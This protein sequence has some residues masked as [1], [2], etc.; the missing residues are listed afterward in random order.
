MHQMTLIL[1]GAVSCLSAALAQ[2]GGIQGTVTSIAPNPVGD[3]PVIATAVAGA[4]ITYRRVPIYGPA[5]AGSMPQLAPGEVL[6]DTSVVADANGKHTVSGLPAGNYVVC[7]AAA[8]QPLLD[9]CRWG[10]S[11]F[12][13]VQIGSI[14]NLNIQLE[15]GVYLAVRVNDPQRLLPTSAE[16]LFDTPRLIVGVVFGNGAFL[17]AP[18]ISADMG[19][20]NYE[21]AVP[22]GAPLYLW[23]FSRHVALAD[24]QGKAFPLAGAAVPFNAAPGAGQ[25]FT[26]NVSGSL[27]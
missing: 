18:Q 10:L 16:T 19:G 20:R 14:S 17:A 15:R 26:I 23:L 13:R 21:V 5:R 4:R 7:A 24:A 2:T 11:P 9:P 27:P 1:V 6:F 22:T 8:G 3:S 12:V 25:S